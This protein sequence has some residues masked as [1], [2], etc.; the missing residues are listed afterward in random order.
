MENSEPSNVKYCVPPVPRPPVQALTGIVLDQLPQGRGIFQRVS[1]L[2]AQ[3][4]VSPGEVTE[5]L[6]E[7]VDRDGSRERVLPEHC[8]EHE[9]LIAPGHRGGLELREEVLEP[10]E[11]LLLDRVEITH[12]A[13][14]LQPGAVP[15]AAARP[16]G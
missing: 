6:R 15:V 13:H 8:Q 4:S 7:A 9:H 1:Y 11:Q 16:S 3:G 2:I 14:E 5:S 10:L 12:D